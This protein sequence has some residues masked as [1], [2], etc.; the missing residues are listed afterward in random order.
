[1]VDYLGKWWLMSEK[2]FV[3]LGDTHI[4]DTLTGEEW[5]APCETTLLE[6]LNEQQDKI[7]ELEK[8]FEDLVDWSTKISK[9]NVLLDE[10]IGRL[11]QENKEL[12]NKLNKGL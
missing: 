7:T 4:K 10:T 11:E 2:R 3:Q 9:R 6:L 1:M 8:N 12:K 5:Y